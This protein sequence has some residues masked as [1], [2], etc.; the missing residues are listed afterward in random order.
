MHLLCR[1]RMRVSFLHPFKTM[2]HST[3]ENTWI[4][5]LDRR[6]CRS[7]GTIIALASGT[8]TPT[9][10]YIMKKHGALFAAQKFRVMNYSHGKSICN[11]CGTI[12]APHAISIHEVIEWLKCARKVEW[13]PAFYHAF[14][15]SVK[16]GRIPPQPHTVPF[17]CIVSHFS[18]LRRHFPPRDKW[19]LADTFAA[20]MEKFESM[21]RAEHK[22]G[23]KTTQWHVD[24]V[25]WK[26]TARPEFARILL[27]F[28]E[29]CI[30]GC[31]SRCDCVFDILSSI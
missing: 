19:V 8:T 10:K 24:K 23:I 25:N 4:D 2:A 30:R 18:F 13:I 14:D 7:E 12:R 3:C 22:S 16:E 6:R 31:S 11:F 26:A 17:G 9:A 1:S 28:D 20:L 15:Q 21:R 5:V 29:I 27:T